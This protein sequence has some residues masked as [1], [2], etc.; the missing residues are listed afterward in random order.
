MFGLRLPCPQ[1]NRQRPA[2][3]P[4]PP[5]KRQL[6][7]C[8]NVGKVFGI[9]EIA[10]STENPEGNRQIKAGTFFAH[11]GR[12]EID[13]GL[14][15]RKEKRAVINRRSNTLPRLAYCEIGQANYN[16]RRRL[17]GLAAHGSQIDF[18]VDQIGIDAIDGSALSAEEH[19]SQNKTDLACHSLAM[20]LLIQKEYRLKVCATGKTKRA[21][22]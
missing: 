3:W 2:N 12:R 19:G 8:Q 16:H 20:I 7:N 18:D 22:R 9:A 6:S 15:K 17:I 1:S 4:H 14:V 10:I 13:R 11:V 5:I 21:S